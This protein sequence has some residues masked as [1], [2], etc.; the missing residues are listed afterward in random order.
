[1]SYIDEATTPGGAELY[2]LLVT[3]GLGAHFLRLP[4]LQPAF[5]PGKGGA[6]EAGGVAGHH[7]LA[8]LLL[9][10]LTDRHLVLHLVNVVFG[11]ALSLV[12]SPAHLLSAL[13]PPAVLDDRGPADL[14]T[15]GAAETPHGETKF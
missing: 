3:A 10:R 9:H 4:L 13:L 15:D 7:V 1:M 12:H 11:P 8:L 2:R 6:L 14:R 5:L